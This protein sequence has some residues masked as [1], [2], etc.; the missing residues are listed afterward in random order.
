MSVNT[1]E[2]VTPKSPV[3]SENAYNITRWFALVLLPAV[4]ALYFGLA[5]IWDLPNA[6][7]VVGTITLVVTFLG[8]LLQ[9]DA[10]RYTKYEEA[11]NV[12]TVEAAPVETEDGESAFAMSLAKP[13][14]EYN[15]GDL[16]KMRVVS[17]DRSDA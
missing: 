3:F 15:E 7:Q 10:A 9:V 1:S 12:G 11:T 2:E 13:L 6:E 4:G 5:N 14:Y 8:V 17:V 16:V